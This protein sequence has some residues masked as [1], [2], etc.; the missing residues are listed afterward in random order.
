MLKRKWRKSHG[1]KR[2]SEMDEKITCNNIICYTEKLQFEIRI[3]E[4]EAD[5]KFNSSMLAK[6]TDLAREAEIR[7]MELK[8]ELQY[9]RLSNEDLE[10]LLE[11]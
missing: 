5:L 11:D 3:K 9:S 6:Q 8:K 2:R 7:V 4:L 1:T 10:K